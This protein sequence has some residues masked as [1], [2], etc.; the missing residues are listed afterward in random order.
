M[1]L[2]TYHLRIYHVFVTHDSV[3]VAVT[4]C[5]SLSHA[6]SPFASVYSD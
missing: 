2:N 5:E 4:A 6:L 3:G 1:N